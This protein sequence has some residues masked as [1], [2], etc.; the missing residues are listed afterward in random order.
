LH[1]IFGATRF[2]TNRIRCE[3]QGKTKSTRAL[4]VDIA[5]KT[6]PVGFKLFCYVSRETKD[7]DV[8]AWQMCG[9]KLSLELRDVVHENGKHDWE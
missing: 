7:G 8:P 2:N 1:R 5:R 9:A 3:G 4:T 6:Q